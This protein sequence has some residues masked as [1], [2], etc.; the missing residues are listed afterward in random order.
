MLLHIKN[1]L[2]SHRIETV[3]MLLKDAPFVK[4]KLSAGKE[5]QRVKNNVELS[6]QSELN[7]QLNQIVMNSLLQHPEYQAAAFPLKVAGAFYARYTQG[8]QYGF[9][10]DDPVMG[11]M[12]GR[13]RADIATTI[14]LNSRE[15]YQGGE[16]VV[17][18]ATGEQRFKP[19]IG[20]AIIY[21]A[22]TWHKVTEV[23]QGERLVAV[24][25]AQSMIKDVQQRE[26]LYQLGQARDALLITQ[27][28]AEETHKVS[29]SYAN[30]I[31]MWSEV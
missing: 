25:W 6:P 7:Q 24:T 10:V 14:C 4:G 31:R 5:A 19:D 11:P 2:D 13:Y 15:D 29:T 20:D 1:L 26:L 22:N 8:M 27:A 17:R 28:D 23:T 30:L 18:T 16:L 12:N 3:N 21:P 9:H